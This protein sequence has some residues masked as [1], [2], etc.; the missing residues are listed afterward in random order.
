MHGM[1]KRQVTVIVDGN[2]G[3]WV[4]AL[5]KK[6]MVSPDGALTMI[7]TEIT[8]NIVTLE[9]LKGI[10]DYIKSE[11]DY[12]PKKLTISLSLWDAPAGEVDIDGTFVQLIDKDVYYDVSRNHMLIWQDDEPVYENNNGVVCRDRIA[13]ADTYM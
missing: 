1:G 8:D 2:S 12:V 3:E 7:R 5:H 6:G 4:S 9:K 11:F 10:A 13:L